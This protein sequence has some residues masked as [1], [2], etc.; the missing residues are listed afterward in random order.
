MTDFNPAPLLRQMDVLRA[1]MRPLAPHFAAQQDTHTRELY[2]TML[3]VMI[4]SKGQVSETENRLYGMLLLSLNLGDNRAKYLELAQSFDL[5]QLKD[6]FKV[7]HTDELKQAFLLDAMILARLDS[8]ISE[9]QGRLLSEMT[10][11]FALPTDQLTVLTNLVDWV[12]GLSESIEKTIFTSYAKYY[13]AKDLNP[14]TMEKWQ[15]SALCDEVW[16]DPR[17]MLMWSRVSVG[18]T[19]K[20]GKAVGTAKTMDWSTACGAGKNERVAGFDD[21]RTPT[22]DELKTLMIEGKAGYNCPD[23]VLFKPADAFGV[24]WSSSPNGN[25]DAWDVNFDNGRSNDNNKGYDNL[26]RVVR[27]SQ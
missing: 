9:M 26:V 8:P 10:D 6:F 1:D 17:N 14:M 2:A 20:D 21:W 25:N 16:I 18:Q 4:L 12:L 15:Q 5:E 19:F 3:A 7:L 11:C 23:G 24:Y 27:G 22:I 13:N